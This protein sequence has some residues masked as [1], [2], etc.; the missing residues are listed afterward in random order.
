MNEGE[1]THNEE[2]KNM[3]MDRHCHGIAWCRGS[4]G[5]SLF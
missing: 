3:E 2:K 1:E 4:C 5:V